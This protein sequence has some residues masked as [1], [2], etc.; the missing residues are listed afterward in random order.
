MAILIVVAMPGVFADRQLTYT[1]VLDV[2]STIIENYFSNVQ[3][4]KESFPDYFQEITILDTVE[5]VQK[6]QLE[7]NLNGFK[8]SPIVLLKQN[9][10]EYLFK[11]INGDLKGTSIKANLDQTWGFDGQPNKGTIVNIDADI[12]TS[13]FLSLLGFF[14]D[15]SIRYFMDYFLLK[16]ANDDTPD[17][18]KNYEISKR[19]F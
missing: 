3:S 6:L 4:L 5:D 16:I 8:N 12:K 18:K 15:D 17:D 1:K 10:T 11:I 2:E 14:S 19:T 13:G 9:Q 7:I